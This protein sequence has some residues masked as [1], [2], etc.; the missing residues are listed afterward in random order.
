VRKAEEG[1]AFCKKHGDA[2]FGAM[3]GA[4]VYMEPVDEVEHL[5]GEGRP[6]EMARARGKVIGADK[7]G[8]VKPLLQGGS[9]QGA[10][11]DMGKRRE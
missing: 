1:S 8:G 9:R 6:C 7:G 3:L 5:C 4:L 11:S 10:M 2:I